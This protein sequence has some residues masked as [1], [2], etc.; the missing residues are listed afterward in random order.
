G[1]EVLDREDG[2][3]RHDPDGLGL[4][5]APV[6][7]PGVDLRELL[8]GCL[9]RAGVLERLACTLLAKDL[10]D[11]AA[12]ARTTSR[13]QAV[14]ACV[15]RRK[16]SRS[17]V[18]G[19]CPVTTCFSSSQSGSVYSQTPPPFFRSLGSGSSKPSSQT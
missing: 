14:S 2:S 10:V 4:V 19:P 8:V 17:S 3:A 9:E 16:P 13:T 7:V 15:V 1:L 6:E 11:H 18:F 12:S 5:A